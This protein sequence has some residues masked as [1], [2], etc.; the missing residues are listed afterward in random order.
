MTFFVYLDWT[1]EQVPRC[2]YV[3]K[4]TVPLHPHVVRVL[5]EWRD[6]WSEGTGVERTDD[7]P[8]FAGIGG[9]YVNDF[10]TSDL[11]V[12]LAAYGASVLFD[13]V[14]P[15]TPHA[16]RRTALTL[17]TNA[18]VPDGDVREIAGHAKAGVTRKHYVGEDMQRLYRAVLSIPLEAGAEA[19]E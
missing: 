14:H 4:R 2:F 11:H 15:V 10:R 19:A 12:D 5:R 6:A 3:G 8:V 7:S 9:T 1:L 16:L 18:S 17:L 13:G